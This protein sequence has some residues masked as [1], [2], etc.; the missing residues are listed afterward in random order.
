MR[1]SENINEISAALAEAR[2]EFK[3]IKKSKEAKIKGETAAGKPYEY[4][5]FYADLP[6]IF[7]AIIPAMTKH[8]LSL[9]QGF[10]GGGPE[11]AGVITKIFHKSGQWY[12]TFYPLIPKSGKY[13]VDMQGMAAGW[14]YSR[15]QAI[16]GILGISS[17]DD[18]DGDFAM[19]SGPKPVYSPQPKTAPPP[20]Q[21]RPAQQQAAR[22]PVP[23]PPPMN[24][25]PLPMSD[26][27]AEPPPNM[28]MN[29]PPFPKN[30]Q[31]KNY[32]PG[33]APR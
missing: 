32:A 21:Q 15:R 23:T 14:T 4:V 11:H 18:T 16:N 22:I 17:D 24:L 31:P 3:D 10:T 13:G 2:G 9:T 25:P 28:P 30:A 19:P 33:S 5:Y 20:P 1:H 26:P 27:K 8:G 6:A 7:D 29:P 12:E